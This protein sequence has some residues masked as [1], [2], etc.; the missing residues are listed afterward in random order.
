VLS[1]ID[2]VQGV[3]LVCYPLLLP[4][5]ALFQVYT[6]S[7]KSL[8]SFFTIFSLITILGAPALYAETTAGEVVSCFDTQYYKYNGVAISVDPE[9]TNVSAGRTIHFQ[10]SLK[11]TIASPIAEGVLFAK[12]FRVVKKDSV[13]E[14]GYDVVGQFVAQKNISI[15]GNAAASVAFDWLVPRSLPSGEYK[16]ALYFSKTEHMDITGLNFTDDITGALSSFSVTGI[17]GVSDSVAFEKNATTV[18]A[19][20][21]AFA[22]PPTV[23]SGLNSV[24]VTTRIINPTQEKKTVS[25]TWDLHE[26]APLKAPLVTFTEEVTLNPGESKNLSHTFPYQGHMVGFVLVSAR[27]DTEPVSFLN[28]RYIYTTNNEARFNDVGLTSFPIVKGDTATMYGCFH[29]IGKD[30]NKGDASVTLTAY[31]KDGSKIAEGVYGGEVS[32]VPKIGYKKDF[33]AKEDFNYIKLVASVTTGSVTNEQVVVYDCSVANN[34][35]TSYSEDALAKK[36]SEKH[37]TNVKIILAV[38]FIT[39]A[40]IGLDLFVER[41][42]KKFVR[43]HIVIDEGVSEEVKS[44]KKVVKK[45][46]SAK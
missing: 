45:R 37:A 11:N 32:S 35:C 21:F 4:V 29:A 2:L 23:I 44:T 19:S 31:N 15:A 6:V 30:I 3:K 39:F 12:V 36:A 27:V 33:I 22:R 13:Q 24:P 16:L 20:K 34:L 9:F 18:N 14:N 8:F 42:K 46:A 26:W 7:M 38:A 5:F 1:F 17:K 40:L 28:I 25:V 41:R 10:G 43:G